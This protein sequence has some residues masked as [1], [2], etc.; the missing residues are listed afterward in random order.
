[1][2]KNRYKH[3][4]ENNSGPRSESRLCAKLRFK[5]LVN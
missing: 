1:M 5:C 2:I 4:V 3:V